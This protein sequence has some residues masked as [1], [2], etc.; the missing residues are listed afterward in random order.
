MV[1]LQNVFP[2]YWQ[3]LLEWSYVFQLLDKCTSEK[4]GYITILL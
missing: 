1:Q 3:L 4:K 2:Q